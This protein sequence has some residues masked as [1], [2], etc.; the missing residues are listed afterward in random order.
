MVWFLIAKAIRINIIVNQIVSQC[1]PD[2]ERSEGEES[3]LLNYRRDSS[4]ALLPQNDKMVIF[5]DCD[6]E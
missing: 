5:R 2:R 3:R 4:V 6:T 1:H